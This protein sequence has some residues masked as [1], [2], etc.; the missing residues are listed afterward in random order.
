MIHYTTIPIPIEPHKIVY[1]TP[2]GTAY[3]MSFPG[4]GGFPLIEREP[5]HDREPWNSD[6]IPL[7]TEASPDAF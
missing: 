2:G 4:D 3:S 1:W 6:V 7:P 5:D